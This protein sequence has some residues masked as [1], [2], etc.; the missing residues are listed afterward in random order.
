[1]LGDRTRQEEALHEFGKTARRFLSA[2]GTHRTAYAESMGIC[3][4][5]LHMVFD[6]RFVRNPV[7]GH[8]PPMGRDALE[9]L[10]RDLCKDHGALAAM[11]SLINEVVSPP[12]SS[13]VN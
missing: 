7:S 6:G 2:K 12:G 9:A 11:L 4:E 13:V 5:A 1:M 10:A 3:P 8:H